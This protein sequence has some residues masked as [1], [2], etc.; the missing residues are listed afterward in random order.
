MVII[1]R[2]ES[3][4]GTGFKISIWASSPNLSEKDLAILQ[5]AVAAAGNEHFTNLADKAEEILRTL[6][7][8]RAAEIMDKAAKAVPVEEGADD[9]A[10]VAAVISEVREK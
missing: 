7:P 4:G 3:D 2:F 5:E 10:A 6:G 1:D 8:E 9:A